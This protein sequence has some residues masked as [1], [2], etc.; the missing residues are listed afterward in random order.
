MVEALKEGSF[1]GEFEIVNPLGADAELNR[2]GIQAVEEV[3]KEAR[4]LARGLPPEKREAIEKICTEIE[5][6]MKELA[7]LQARGE[8]RGREGERE[9]E[10]ASIN[11]IGLNYTT[12][13]LPA[14]SPVHFKL[15]SLIESFTHLQGDS[16]RAKEIALA[17]Q[18]K[19]DELEREMRYAAAKRVAEDFKD[20]LGP[21]NALTAA[22]M[23]PPGM[24]TGVHAVK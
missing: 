18:K 9:R 22:T 19:M 5:A 13:T 6:L 16:E 11:S 1:I 21:L 4:R 14:S 3:L 12:Y 24:H 8:V 2:R 7:E 15:R 23:A 10:R 17:L 20:P